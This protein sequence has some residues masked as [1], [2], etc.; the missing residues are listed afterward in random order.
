M[1]RQNYR[2]GHI[3]ENELF[4]V[5]IKTFFRGKLTY[6]HCNKGEEMIPTIDGKGATL[7]VRKLPKTDTT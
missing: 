3:T 4:D 7:L 6:S 1:M 2:G 5:V